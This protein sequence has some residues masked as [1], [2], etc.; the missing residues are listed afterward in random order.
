MALISILNSIKNQNV[1]II[2]N[3]INEDLIVNSR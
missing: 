2:L 3:D 1:T